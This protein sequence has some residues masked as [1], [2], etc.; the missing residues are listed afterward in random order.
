MS[1]KGKYR[2]VNR[3]KYRGNPSEIVYRSLLELRFM[4]YCDQNQ[5]VIE[6]SSE[7]VVIPYRSPVD[8]KIHRYFP[9]FLIT[10]KD[11]HN[12]VHTYLIEIKPDKQT[13]QPQKPKDNRGKKRYLREA[14]TYA[15][16]EAKWNAAIAYC[17]KQGWQFK[18]LTEK[19]LGVGKQG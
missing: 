13:V 11:Q 8:N 10:V 12:A 7:E 17:E 18:I 2:P 15:I 5:N 16:N 14:K 9:D 4:R 3:H 19:T 6:W 1:Y